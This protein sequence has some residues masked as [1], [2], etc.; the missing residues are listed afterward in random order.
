MKGFVVLSL[1]LAVSFSAHAGENSPT[2]PHW[3]Y[4][5]ERGP[6]AWGKLTPEF[7]ACAAGQTQSP[8]NIADA[9]SAEMVPITPRYR[10][11][12]LDAVYD[13][14]MVQVNV[15]AGSSVAIGD[16]TYRL[17]TYHFHTPSEHLVDGRAY[18][19]EIHF[20]HKNDAGEWAVLGV[21][22]EPGE[23][24]LAAQEVWDN[25]PSKPGVHARQERI[26]V[27]AR[28]LMPETLGYYRYTGSLTT[29][30]C[31]EG[32]NWFVLKTPMQFSAEQ[33]K[34]ISDVMGR[35]ARPVQ[36]RHNRI[37]LGTAKVGK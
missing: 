36:E 4:E 1:A 5:G 16:R 35:N 34:Q 22:V 31:R 27:N 8:I 32:V 19:M 9:E 7:S 12:P 6:A 23:A 33:I 37:V 18:P 28:D 26:L 29:P 11:S 15:A 20:V 13:G 25:L 17:L 30:P 21:L 24:N 14:R 3:S 2:D 10:V